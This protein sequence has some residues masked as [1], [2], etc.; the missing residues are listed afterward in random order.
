M[1][2]NISNIAKCTYL[3][4]I[5]TERL[6]YRIYIWIYIISSV[7]FYLNIQVTQ[8]S[9]HISYS[10]SLAYTFFR[11]RHDKNISPFLLI[12]K[13]ALVYSNIYESK[14]QFSTEKNTAY[15]VPPHRKN[16]TLNPSAPGGNRNQQSSPWLNG[17]H[18]IF[19]D[20]SHSKRSKEEEE[21]KI[22][23]TKE[24]KRRRNHPI[25]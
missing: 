6:V 23:T 2:E 7:L 1:K 13:T 16:S 15:R 20:T 5:Y 17:S 18:L 25:Q 8:N 11:K 4:Y 3:I 14:T 24:K 12:L 9:L 10:D 21:N 19:L 22:K